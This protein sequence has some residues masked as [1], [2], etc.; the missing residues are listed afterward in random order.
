M[1]SND[2]KLTPQLKLLTW[3]IEHTTINNNR[4][5]ITNKEIASIYL[6]DNP[7]Y[8]N[9]IYMAIGQFLDIIYGSDLKKINVPGGIAYNIILVNKPIKEVFIKDYKNVYDFNY[10]N[11]INQVVFENSQQTYNFL[12]KLFKGINNDI[13]YNIK[14][15]DLIK[16][17]N[18][19]KDIILYCL[20]K[21][22]PKQYLKYYLFYC[23]AFINGHHLSRLL[24]NEK[25]KFKKN[26][27]CAVCGQKHNL[28]IHHIRKVNNAPYLEFNNKNFIVLCDKCHKQHHKQEVLKGVLKNV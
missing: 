3:L 4:K 2:F 24:I 15:N 13:D 20:N 23:M 21:G 10:Y 17:D 9:K 5:P 18:L 8:N 7:S 22:I 1:S 11:H 6:K 14:P 28:T 26:K 16:M 12:N 19:S 25:K 27:V